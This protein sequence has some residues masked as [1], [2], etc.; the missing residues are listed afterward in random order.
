MPMPQET[1]KIPKYM[2]SERLK[3]PRNDSYSCIL[4]ES[5]CHSSQLPRPCGIIRRWMVRIHYGSQDTTS[6]VYRTKS[7]RCA[8]TAMLGKD[9]DILNLSFHAVKGSSASF[10]PST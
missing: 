4:R 5:V 2:D 1:G 3:I 7:K 9:T 10:R 8:G 6:A